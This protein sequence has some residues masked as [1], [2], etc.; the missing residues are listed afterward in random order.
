MTLSSSGVEEKKLLLNEKK[1]LLSI[2]ISSVRYIIYPAEIQFPERNTRVYF[3]QDKITRQLCIFKNV[4]NL[5]YIAYVTLPCTVMAEKNNKIRNKMFYL[6]MLHVDIQFP[7][8]GQ[9]SAAN[10]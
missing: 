9:L 6:K 7:T 4:Q 1:K 8:H 2:D 10:C 3:A 5:A